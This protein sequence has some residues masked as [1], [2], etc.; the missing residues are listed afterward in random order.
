MCGVL[1]L[2]ICYKMRNFNLLPNAFFLAYMCARKGVIMGVYLMSLIILCT[3]NCSWPLLLL[4]V[5]FNQ[6][7]CRWVTPT[8]MC[9]GDHG[10]LLV[11]PTATRLGMTDYQYLFIRECRIRLWH[12]ARWYGTSWLVNFWVVTLMGSVRNPLAHYHFGHNLDEP[13][14]HVS[15]CLSRRY[16]LSIILGDQTFSNTLAR[17]RKSGHTFGGMTCEDYFLQI[18]SRFSSSLNFSNRTTLVPYT[19]SGC[20]CLAWAWFLCGTNLSVL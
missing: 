16:S 19:T 17:L 6:I 1:A 9:H 13:G 12:L 15:L 18:E 7:Y 3:T 14:Q 10:C 4:I 20:F 8:L 2:P 5:V 11:Q